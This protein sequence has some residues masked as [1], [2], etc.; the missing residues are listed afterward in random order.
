MTNRKL[1]RKLQRKEADALDNGSYTYDSL[2]KK[3][4]SF[5]A[6]AFEITVG[7]KTFESAK[8]Q[9]PTL[10]VE[11]TADGNA[12]GCSFTL[13]GQYDNESNAWLN[14]LA[15]TIKAGATVEVKGGYVKQKELFY[16]YVDDYSFEF[17]QSAAPRITVSGLD[18]LGYLMSLREPLYAGQK[19]AAQIVKE[20]M[21]KSV[22]AGFAKK[23]TI[24]SLSGFETPIVKEQIDD[25]KFL[26]LMAQR[27]GMSLFAVAGELVFDDVGSKTS[28]ILT[29]KMGQGL[30][31]FQKRV[32]LAHQV[33]KVE[34]WGR[35]V[36]QKAVKGE[37]SKVTAEGDGKSAAE[38]VP[39]LKDAVLREY[40]EYAR[41]QEE[42]KLLAERRLNGIAMGLV[43]GGGSCIGIPELIPGRYIKI[44]GADDISN[45]S[46]FM[47]KVRHLF[48]D[49]QYLTFFE[50]KGAK[51]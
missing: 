17:E 43:S 41:T 9:I 18:G 35:D 33:G 6:P 50:F 47:T 16:G 8:V 5:T 11:L 27:Y 3:Y 36:N 4:D 12:G 24:G 7:G 45:G 42:C 34:V 10:E 23:V 19:Q 48:Q 1:P 25:W 38:L 28:P 37:A 15:K 44:D 49:N 32:S 46:Y 26:N 29:L 13:E 39:G 31:S 40:S 22:S 21:N 20:I 14:G 30:H 51:A 2:S